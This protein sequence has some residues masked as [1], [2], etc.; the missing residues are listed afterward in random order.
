MNALTRA[1]QLVSAL[2]S[3]RKTILAGLASIAYGVALL[4]GHAD[5][6]QVQAPP[7]LVPG[8]V[9]FDNLEAQLGQLAESTQ[10]SVDA[11]ARNTGGPANTGAIGGLGVLVGLIG[12]FSRN[13]Q[14]KIQKRLDEAHAALEAIRQASG[15]PR[16]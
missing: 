3:N 10:E 4:T 16:T 1:L 12:L 8:A 13:A 14:S 7:V 5:P 15:A 11:V 2:T 6:D 9:T